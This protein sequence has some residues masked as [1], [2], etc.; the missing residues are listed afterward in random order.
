[1]WEK[2]DKKKFHLVT[3]STMIEYNPIVVYF[4]TLFVCLALLLKALRD[5]CAEEDEVH[6]DG[7]NSREI[8]TR[9]FSHKLSFI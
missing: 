6:T 2:T 9:D 8:F 5:M 3:A 1:V 4:L 7:L